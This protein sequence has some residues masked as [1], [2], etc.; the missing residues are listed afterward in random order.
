MSDI[1]KPPS[2]QRL[3]LVL[4]LA[5]VALN[6]S[7]LIG[8]SVMPWDAMDEFYPTVFFNAHSLRLGLAPWWN[9]SIYSGYPQIADPQGM[10]FSPLL[11]AWMLLREAPGPVWF[12]WGVLLHLLMGGIA[13][14][15]FLRQ[16][17]VNAA[18]ALIGAT[19]YMAGGVAASRLEHTPI[20]VAYGYAPVVLL[21]L[22][23]FLARPKL[24]HAVLLGLAAGALAV[25][26][27]QVT[28]LFVLA[29]IAY[30]I[31]GT[32]QRWRSYST[33][34]RWRWIGGMVAA[35]VC[36]LALALPQLL[37]SWAFMSVS[38]RATM[39]LSDAAGASLDARTFLSL[40][41]PNALHALRGSYDG[42]ASVVEAYLYIGAIPLL[43]M[44]ALPRAWRARHGR[45][46]LVFFGIVALFACLYMFGVHTPLY[47]WLYDWMPGMQHFRRPS[48][49][50]YLL[51]FSLAIMAGI[52]ASQLNL[53]CRRDITILLTVA[54]CWLAGASLDMRVEGMRWP[55]F[56]LLA[57]ACAALALWR[58]QKPGSEWRATLWL[59]AVL[60]VDYRCFNLNGRFNQM[61][62]T[63]QA[64]QNSPIVKFL[65]NEARESPPGLAPRIETQD[66]SAAWDNLM[67]V[68]G[69]WSTQG[70][71][72]L[73][74]SLYEQWY[75]ARASSAA[76]AGTTAFN[77]GPGGPVSRLLGARYLV[78]GHRDGA[79]T[80][81]PSNGYRRILSEKD[82]EL[83]STDLA[84]PRLL[85]PTHV[86]L[87]AAGVLPDASLF[88]ATDFR[89][90]LLLTPRDRHDASTE[91][92]LAS[93]CTGRVN[94]AVVNATPTQQHIRVQA[95]D[96]GWVVVSELDFPGWQAELDGKAIS[97]HRGNGMF[98]AVCVPAG[99]H[100][101]HF[102]FH[103]WAM[104]AYAWLHAGIKH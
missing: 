31:I 32:A 76:A 59:L 92:P 73:R 70:Y 95:Q 82:A 72:P 49:G 43:A 56:T 58:L 90:T 29:L 13:M 99:E 4:C 5:W 16:D 47:R 78:I 74:Y 34:D 86:R 12:S 93:A 22:R 50:A 63:A 17:K 71:N 60:I 20:V 21:F 23:H 91:R 33:Q 103:P 1:T 101:L 68:Q 97:I 48:D 62:D 9:P 64:F 6:A 80:L 85:N 2:F 14:L 53:Q 10:L 8:K 11:M 75:G 54:M 66:T 81:Q 100:D 36:A 102:R 27:V 37:F 24:R 57:A 40:L 98:R 41:A 3:V 15:A 7:L 77:P 42:P 55:A 83:W 65:S 52:A 38:N 79:A 61:K 94:A 25:H 44:L 67:T 45:S 89:N 18:G 35:S 104:V 39:A 19:V 51:N 84:Y 96:S 30:C 69:L 87:F 46:S 88:A 28:Y 26:L